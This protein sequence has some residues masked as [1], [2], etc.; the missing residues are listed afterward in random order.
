M[1][2][3]QR[4]ETRAELIRSPRSILVVNGPTKCGAYLLASSLAAA[5]PGIR[6]VLARRGWAGEK[7]GLFEHPAYESSTFHFSRRTFHG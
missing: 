6:R 1:R 7:S 2:T 3:F 5:L 4:S